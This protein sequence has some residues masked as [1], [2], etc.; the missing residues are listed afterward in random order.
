MNT[1]IKKCYWKQNYSN[2]NYNINYFYSY[3]LYQLKFIEIYKVYIYKVFIE[4]RFFPFTV[5][6]NILI[7]YILVNSDLL[8]QIE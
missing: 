2:F 8:T 6:T 5:Y 7:Y 4:V 3:A 1:N